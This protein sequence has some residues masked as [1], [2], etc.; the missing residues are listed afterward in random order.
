MLYTFTPS[1]DIFTYVKY[2][3]P[4][5]ILNLK[6][7]VRKSFKFIKNKKSYSY[8]CTGVQVYRYMGVHT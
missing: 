2:M 1:R 7:I 8:P 5:H 3:Y 6:F 4:V